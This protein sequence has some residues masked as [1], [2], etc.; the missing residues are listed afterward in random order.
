MAVKKRPLK[1]E[2]FLNTVARKLGH[3]AGAL[4]KATEDLAENL[5]ALPETVTKRV[6]EAGHIAPAK[7]SQGSARRA[8]K[9]LPTSRRRKTKAASGVPKRKRKNKVA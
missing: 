2:P 6:R 5:S 3:A 7:P 9:L 8:K 1:Q 4:T